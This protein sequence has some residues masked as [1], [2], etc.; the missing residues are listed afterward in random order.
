[1]H[2]PVDSNTV[3]PRVP[4]N[5]S[6]PVQESV[7]FPVIEQ[8][9]LLISTFNPENVNNIVPPKNKNKEKLKLSN[10]VKFSNVIKFN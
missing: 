8:K 2:N 1:M 6:V 7:S 4:V 5:V 3:V 9:Q 10:A